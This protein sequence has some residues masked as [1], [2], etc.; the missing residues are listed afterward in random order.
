[1]LLAPHQMYAVSAAI[2]P[3]LPTQAIAASSVKIR[4]AKP[5]QPT[6]SV[7]AALLVHTCRTV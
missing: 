3:T 1:V 6:T 4:T 5:A 7:R 2:Y